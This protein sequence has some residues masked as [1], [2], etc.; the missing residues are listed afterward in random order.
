MKDTHHQYVIQATSSVSDG[1]MDERFSD[2]GE[3]ALNRAGFFS[4]NGAEGRRRALMSVDHGEVI[5]DVEGKDFGR[6]TERTYSAEALV[7]ED[8]T[9]LL[10]LLTADC[11][12]V[13]Y[14][15]PVRKVCALAHLGWR[16]IT[17]GLHTKV[18]D[19]METTYGSKSE[20]L[21]VVIGPG[22]GRESYVFRNVE[23]RDPS[24]RQFILLEDDGFHVD[25]KGYV[26]HGL[27]E[28]GVVPDL[29]LVS[30]IDTAQNRSYYSHF[31]SMRTGEDE[32]RM[33]TILGLRV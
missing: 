11:L 10:C 27:I 6:S 7:T 21:L 24:W 3:V 26:S 31:R 5:L 28:R 33:L 20:D 25:L 14:V 13:S 30:G 4:H 23:Q 15:D 16:P 18:I 8:P 29:I 12:P 22:I 19:H 17:H 32:G 9:V 2:P 1:N